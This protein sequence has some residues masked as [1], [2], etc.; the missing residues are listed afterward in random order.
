MTQ[1]PPKRFNPWPFAIL[2]FF[3]FLLIATAAFV[4]MSQSHKVDLVSPD[5]YEQEVKFQDQIDRLNRTAGLGSELGIALD[6]ATQVLRIQLP[7]PHGGRSPSGSVA[8]Y[9]PAEAELDRR[10]PLQTDALGVQSM[11]LTGIASGLWRVRVSWKV[12]Q[13]EFF[14]ETNIVVRPRKS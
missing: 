4:R 9:R 13:E 7:R 1:P 2:G 8:L 6:D 5:Y 10:F 12:E 11:D 14:G 3:A